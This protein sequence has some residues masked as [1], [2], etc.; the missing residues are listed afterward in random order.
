MRQSIL[1]F[2]N[3]LE[4][5]SRWGLVSSLFLILGLAVLSIVLRWF[6]TSPSW[7]EPL[8]RHL[9]FLSSFLG[10]SI[11]TSRKLHI[12]VDVLTKVIEASSFKMLNWLHRNLI[13]LFCVITCGFLTVSSYD[14]FVVEKEFGN[15]AFLN[16]HSSYLVGIIPFGMG[17]ICLRFFNQL[18]L[19]IAHGDSDEHSR[20]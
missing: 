20:I 17:L 5:I 6:G 4:K 9:V 15:Q 1:Y 8:I 16:I 10:G 12:K 14:F 13:N 7:I 11:A 18:L 19:G 3:I 2:D